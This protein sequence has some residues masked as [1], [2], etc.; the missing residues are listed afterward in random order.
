MKDLIKKIKALAAANQEIF[1]EW[2]RGFV[3][4]V[5]DR[6]EKYGDSTA[7][8][9]KQ[10]SV[11]DKLHA[12]IGESKQKADKPAA[13]SKTKVVESNANADPFAAMQVVEIV[14]DG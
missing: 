2:E 8:S 12:K 10:K 9:D 3:E 13:A 5:A 4:G 1:N 6:V 7:I 11:I 14:Q